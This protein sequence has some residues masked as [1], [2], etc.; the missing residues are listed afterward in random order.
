[1]EKVKNACM[2][3]TSDQRVVCC[4]DYDMTAITAEYTAIN[5]YFVTQV[6]GRH[7]VTAPNAFAFLRLVSRTVSFLECCPLV[8]RSTEC[9]N[10]GRVWKPV[11]AI[12]RVRRTLCCQ[13]AMDVR[14]ILHFFFARVRRTQVRRKRHSAPNSR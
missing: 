9:P 12:E 14:G 5:N 11:G 2:R 7:T 3:H 6:F 1:M 4:Y 8:Y 13:R 10:K